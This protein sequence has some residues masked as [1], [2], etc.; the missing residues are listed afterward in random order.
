M[1]GR[2][3]WDIDLRDGQMAESTLARLLGECRIEVKTDEIC[4]KSGKLFVEFEC[5]ARKS[6]LAVTTAAYW[7]FQY[8][9]CKWLIVPT[10]T[11]RR[12]ATRAFKERFIVNG[13]DEGAS[14]GVLIP[15]KWFVETELK[16]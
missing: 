5:R 10:A 13:G 1:T 8:E 14:R 6:G 2:R 4:R 3:G 9:D 7:A 12:L 11:V 15:I 16:T